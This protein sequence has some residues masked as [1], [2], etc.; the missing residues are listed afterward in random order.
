MGSLGQKV[1]RLE[2]LMTTKLGKRAALLCKADL[3]THIVGEFPELQGIM[4]ETYARLSGEEPDL[5]LSL[6]EYYQPLGPSD[7][8][9]TQPLSVELALADKI[10]TLAGFIGVGIKPS[11]SKDPLGL[12]RAALG[13]IRLSQQTSD[14][15]FDLFTLLRKALEVY[16]G[17]GINLSLDTKQQVI[18]FIN[19]RLLSY[20]EGQAIPCAKA[21]LATVS[22]TKPYNVWALQ[23]RCLA[24]QNFLTTEEGLSLKAAYRRAT[25]IVGKGQLLALTIDQDRL[26]ENAEKELYEQIQ[27]SLPAY[28]H[29]LSTHQYQNLMGRLSCLRAPIDHFFNTVMVNCEDAPVRNNRYALLACFI[30]LVNQ[31]ADFHHL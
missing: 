7:V 13:I 9:P 14:H 19:D 6:K 10:D 21:V 3:V 29:L 17:Q 2:S 23:E 15:D 20:L 25:G 18:H 30:S 12:R 27:L 4:G 5:A 1:K 16:K 31:I 8:C 22:M 24:L 11:G 26:V 28:S